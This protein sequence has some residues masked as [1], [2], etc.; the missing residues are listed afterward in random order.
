MPTFLSG[1]PLASLFHC[2]E[3]AAVPERAEDL[4]PA[5]GGRHAEREGRL[6]GVQVPRLF[7][8]RR[9]Q[10]QFLGDRVLIAVTGLL[11][12][13]GGH[14]GRPYDDGHQHELDAG[15]QTEPLTGRSGTGRVVGRRI[16]HGD[17]HLKTNSVPSRRTSD[18]FRSATVHR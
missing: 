3:P 12:L 6:V 13:P 10:L 15:A 8:D 14:Q 18:S 5:R 1:F 11:E 17:T 4:G 9:L 2:R 7:L 16:G